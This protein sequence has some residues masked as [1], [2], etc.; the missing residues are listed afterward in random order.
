GVFSRLDNGT[1]Y[2]RR[3]VKDERDRQAT[4][5]RVKK[6]RCNATVTHDVTPLYVDED[7]KNLE[8]KNKTNSKVEAFTPLE[9][10]V[11]LCIERGWQGIEIRHCFSGA[12]DWLASKRNSSDYP[13][14][15]KEL[16]DAYEKHREKNGKFAGKPKNIF[17]DGTYQQYVVEPPKPPM[18]RALDIVKRQAA[19]IYD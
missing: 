16:L 4:K 11:A 1:I 13:L 17:A 19:G 3:Q 10:S 7:E 14:L 2:S 9:V 5:E 18:V 6:Y 15:G 8:P 12:I